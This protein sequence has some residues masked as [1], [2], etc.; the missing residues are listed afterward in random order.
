MKVLNAVT[1][2]AWRKFSSSSYKR[3]PRPRKGTSAAVVRKADSPAPAAAA[4]ST[5][6]KSVLDNESKGVYWW[7]QQTGET[8]AIGEPRP[9]NW[10]EVKDDQ[11]GEIYYWCP[12]TNET[13]AIGEPRPSHIQGQQ[14]AV[15]LFQQQQ[16]QRAPPVTLG[17]SMVHMAGM[18]FGISLAFAVVGRL[19]F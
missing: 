11:S 14:Q 2:T 17:A 1:E 16:Q 18:G 13:T 10:V 3:P 8:T 15:G 7:N 12:E 19:F 9:L 5:P 4:D 6:W